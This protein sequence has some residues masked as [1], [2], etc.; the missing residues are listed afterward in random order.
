MNT[1]FQEAVLQYTTFVF[2]KSVEKELIFVNIHL[3]LT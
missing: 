1:R 2:R 3:C